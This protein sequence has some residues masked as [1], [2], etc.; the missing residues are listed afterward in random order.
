[1]TTLR[2]LSIPAR[3]PAAPLLALAVLLLAGVMPALAAAP[4]RPAPVGVR[5]SV[6]PPAAIVIGVKMT[7]AASATDLRGRAVP[8][9]RLTLYS[10]GRYLN[11][12]VTDTRGQV[13]FRVPPEAVAQAGT[14][15]L[16]VRFDGNRL[17]LPAS[18]ATTLQIRPANV[19][20]QTVPAVSGVSVT[21]DRTERQ[22]G[23]DG[24]ARFQVSRIGKYELRP[25]FELPA[26]TNARVGFL[27]WQ[28]HV[29]TPNRK[30][31]VRGDAQY[32]IGLRVAY[33][34]SLRFVDLADNPVDPALITSAR[35]SAS[36]SE[37]ALRDFRDVWWEAATA[38][39]RT[40]GL[41]ESRMTWRLNEVEMAGTNVVNRAQQYWE[42]KPGATWTVRLLLYDLAVTTED[43]LT[44]EPVPGKIHLEYP[45]G[46][47]RTQPVAQQ[48]PTHFTA[49]PRGAYTLRF[50]GSGHLPATPVALSRTQEADLR[51]ITS[52]DVAVALGALLLVAA[53]LV[54]IGRRHQLL[55]LAAVGRT[56]VG[57][58]AGFVV[59]AVTHPVR[60]SVVFLAGVPHDISV[61]VGDPFRRL[62]ALPGRLVAVVLGPPRAAVRFVVWVVASIAGMTRAAV[63]S[64]VRVVAAAAERLTAGLRAARPAPVG[65]TQ[66]FQAARSS[67][68][69]PGAF[70]GIRWGS[71]GII[72]PREIVSR[73]EGEL[74]TD[75]FGPVA[76]TGGLGDPAEAASDGDE[77]ADERTCP[78]CSGSVTPGARFCRSCG[79]RLQ[80]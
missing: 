31:D 75:S 35:L 54:W 23:P 12:E 50:E 39:S 49:L 29:F 16:L 48:G 9:L 5:V 66:A 59:R 70:Q 26:E 14:F 15:Q 76:S 56:R 57:A 44:G 65:L 6:V 46:T 36:S 41:Q 27:R 58:A 62:S 17:Y 71:D 30:I 32:N 69:M 68:A 78:S 72:S 18:T 3:R 34:A 79:A 10:N 1:M 21:L 7:V 51:I 42:P 19:D 60:S 45:D 25:K 4:P 80:G 20:I 37:L 61:V 47:R 40:G 8:N 33:R 11:G 43:A 24:R 13:S 55:S 67:T 38:V 77:R 74:G 53:A 63:R 64:V 52:F 73:L 2:T 28:D 22:T